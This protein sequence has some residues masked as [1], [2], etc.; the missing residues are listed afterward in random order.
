MSIDQKFSENR[1][2]APA[3]AQEVVNFWLEAGPEKWFSKDEN[4]D[5]LF[6]Q[7]FY[8]LHFAA[9]RREYDNWAS[10]PYS[11]LALIILLDQFPR[12][13]FRDS[14]HMYAT[15][16]LALSYAERALKA[17][18]IE[19]IE[20]ALRKFMALPYMHSENLSHQVR[21]VE[22]YQRYAPDALKWAHGHHEIIE[23][24]GRFP[25]RNTVLGRH[26][27]ADEQRF[28]DEGGFAG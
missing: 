26:T 17:G 23:K 14:P 9:S 12:N 18:F 15:D 27:T 24:F 25:H 8:D 11:A 5:A 7:K 1:K 4:F 28:L 22:L 2:Q 13:A 21:A 3:Q 19:Q 6:K 20:P 10:Q 16:T